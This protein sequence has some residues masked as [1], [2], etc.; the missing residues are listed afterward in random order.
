MHPP[1]GT[2]PES[3]P[4]G[5][6]ESEI[7]WTERSETARVKEKMDRLIDENEPDQLM[8]LLVMLGEH[9]LGEKER[10]GQ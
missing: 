3:R 7:V 6:M 8:A 1:G 9:L 2:V 4:D 10:K 5:T